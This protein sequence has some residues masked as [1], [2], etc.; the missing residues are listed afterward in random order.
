MKLSHKLLALSGVALADYAC[1]PYDDYGIPFEECVAA[2]PEKT[3]FSDQTDWNTGACKAWEFNPDASFDG[4]DGDC[5]GTNENWGSCGF[6]RH[7][8][9][10]PTDPTDYLGTGGY[11]GNLGST[12]LALGTATNQFTVGGAPFLGGVCKLFIPVELSG[13]ESV[14]VAGVHLNPHFPNK[15][16]AGSFDGVDGS[17]HCFSVVNPSEG[18]RNT[19]GIHNGN[20]AGSAAAGA[21]GGEDIEGDHFHGDTSLDRQDGQEVPFQWNPPQT[22]M[23]SASAGADGDSAVGQNFDVVVH[24]KAAACR[25]QWIREDMQLDGDWG[26][27]DTEPTSQDYPFGAGDINEHDH[28]DSVE[29]RHNLIPDFNTAFTESGDYLTKEQASNP[30]TFDVGRWPNFGAYAAF[31]SF[32]SC[33]VPDG[34][35]NYNNNAFKYVFAD[36]HDDAGCDAG[37]TETSACLAARTIVPA[38]GTNDYRTPDCDG[39]PNNLTYRSNIRQ[40]GTAVTNCGP[41]EILDSDDMRCTWN[42]NFDPS[43]AQP[44]GF[45]TDAEDF[46]QRSES[47]NFLVW[48][49]TTRDRVP[50]INAHNGG[51]LDDPIADLTFSLA[52][53]DHDNADICADAVLTFDLP[54]KYFSDGT[55]TVD[56]TVGGTCTGASEFFINGGTADYNDVAYEAFTKT[57][58]CAAG[59]NEDD[60]DS[61]PDCYQGDEIHFSLSYPAA[62][63]HT[64]RLDPWRTVA[65]IV[66]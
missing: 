27:R 15:A 29:K 48:D 41:G 46:F 59:H 63:A 33:A 23:G 22:T 30:G 65:K 39:D 18:L 1:C 25:S 45:G 34:D 47:F 14:S 13:I 26:D 60:R 3:P 35:E 28:A 5:T 62:D 51:D 56:Y 17:L 21:T 12:N 10:S 57:L 44:N 9:W 4:N 64:G 43:T 7:F 37:T 20:V 36:F 16:I 11:T 53:K 54:T 19:N 24:M 58:V 42:W 32:V 49:S 50:R 8:P 66:V 61:F 6:Q 2:L 31:Y 52:F 38:L 40:A 55:N